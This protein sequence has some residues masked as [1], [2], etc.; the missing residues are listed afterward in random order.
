[1]KEVKLDDKDYSIIFQ[2]A[3]GLWVD[4]A[5]KS[6]HECRCTI[7]SFISL[8]KAKGYIVKDGKIYKE[9]K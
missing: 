9:E 2:G 3:R 5:I 4:T 1:M 8:C 6:H 7:A